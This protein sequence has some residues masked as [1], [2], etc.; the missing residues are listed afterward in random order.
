MTIQLLQDPAIVHLHL[1]EK[2]THPRHIGPAP[3]S[4]IL[5]GRTFILKGPAPVSFKVPSTNERKIDSSGF[6]D[7]MAT[8]LCSLK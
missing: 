7:S 8:I 5:T 3:R 6:T 2:E 1:V 4:F